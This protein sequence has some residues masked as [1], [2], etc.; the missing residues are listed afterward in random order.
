MK[1]ELCSMEGT[2]KIKSPDGSEKFY[3]EHH[4]PSGAIK[5][6]VKVNYFKIYKPLIIVAIIILLFAGA[7]SFWQGFSLDIFMQMFM[8]GFFLIFG[9][10]KALT[11]R[12]FVPSFAEYDPLAK[13]FKLYG[14][15]YPAIELFLA[16]LFL[17]GYLLNLASILTIVILSITTIGIIGAIKRGETLQCVCLGKLLSL[18]LGPVTVFENV[19]MILMAVFMLI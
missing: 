6:S 17:S 13:N 5:L 8:G 7:L 18:P 9:G 15:L 12:D 11:W 19:L 2:Y 1:C 10:M 16:V 14:F 3:C 4:A